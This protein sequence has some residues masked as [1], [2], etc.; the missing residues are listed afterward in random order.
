[1]PRRGPRRPDADGR[2]IGISHAW[3]TLVH[4]LYGADHVGR[5]AL[6]LVDGDEVF[7]LRFLLLFLPPFLDVVDWGGGIRANRGRTEAEVD[8]P[9]T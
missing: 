5:G 2:Q 1:L 3:T 7:L 6:E 8:A 4:G 9:V